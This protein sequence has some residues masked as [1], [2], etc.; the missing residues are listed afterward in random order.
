MYKHIK[1]I[2]TS[3]L[4]ILFY[5]GVILSVN[6]D[7]STAMFTSNFLESGSSTAFMTDGTINNAYFGI[8]AND[9]SPA[10]SRQNV[11]GFTNA[12][13]QA[14]SLG[15]SNIK[16]EANHYYVD[17]SH[18]HFGNIINSQ[19]SIDLVSGVHL[20]LEGAA[21]EQIA[22]G[23]QGY[24]IFTIKEC[25]D[26]SVIGGTL[27]G[28][29]D[30]HDYSAVNSTWGNSHEWGF[31]ISVQGSTNIR[32]AGLNISN[33]TGDGVHIGGS[34]QLSAGGKISRNI[35]I[36]DC[37]IYECRR[38]SISIVG[39][40]TVNISNCRF[41]DNSGF[42][43][44]ISAE[45]SANWPGYNIDLE[46]SMDWPINNIDIH[47]NQF[48]FPES[49]D[50]DAILVHQRTNNIQ[51]TDNQIEGNIV[52]SFGQNVLIANNLVNGII[53]FYKTADPDQVVIEGNWGQME[54]WN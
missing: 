14:G 12:I 52:F 2:I 50:R 42:D 20:S 51:I 33:M 17:T 38:Q 11:V 49:D 13:A 19:N 5:S 6:A 3:A 15:L 28:D 23:E 45:S 22:N 47:H 27:I 39:A 21:F 44:L 41:S 30:I 4:V 29:K 37:T 1:M 48:G 40:D 10:A 25:D 18:V 26:V 34:R 9:D 7:G 16:V 35:Q 53:G 43:Y 32:I 31:G 46:G 8:V 36:D 24:A 54:I